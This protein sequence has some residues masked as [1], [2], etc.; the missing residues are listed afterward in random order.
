MNTRR[1]WL[2]VIFA[3][4]LLACASP[5]P[6]A[7]AAR[8]GPTG[9]IRWQTLTH[10]DTERRFGVYVPTTV[11][12]EPAPL[13]L[14]LHGGGGSAAFT[15]ISEEGRSWR[16]LADAHR[17]IIV[18]PEGLP[19]ANNPDAHHWNDC[20]SGITNPD[21]D[22]NADDVGFLSAVIDWTAAEHPVDARRVYATGQ[23]NGGGMTFRLLTE[24]PERLAA[25]A[26]IIMNMAEPSECGDPEE[27]IPL[28]IV[29]GTA[30]PLVPFTGGCVAPPLCTRGE[31]MS[32]AATIALWTAVIELDGPPKIWQ[33]PDEVPEDQSAIEVHQY[34]DPTNPRRELLYYQVNGGGHI[35][36]GPA[37]IAPLIERIVGPKNRDIDGPADIW[38]FFS[39][40]VRPEIVYGPLVAVSAG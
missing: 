34:F 39:R 35:L 28:M 17:F 38:A 9:F 25:G 30:D 31:V 5:R 15:W 33:L 11:G 16:A 27:P 6:T 23:S 20:R 13:V 36:P 19:D 24:M 40:H 7:S 29:F 21:A 2:I 26:P 22:S 32:T 37:P 18:V 4:V 12:D 8:R 1:I 3:A 10:D 14:L